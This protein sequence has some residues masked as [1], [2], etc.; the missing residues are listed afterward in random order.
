MSRFILWDV[1][2][3]APYLNRKILVVPLP[4]RDCRLCIGTKLAHMTWKMRRQLPVV[5]K[6]MDLSLTIQHTYYHGDSRVKW[7]GRVVTSNH[8]QYTLLN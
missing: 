7:S 4:H 2:Y 1:A 6:E 8:T 5:W 3:E